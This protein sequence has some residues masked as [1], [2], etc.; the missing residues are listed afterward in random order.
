MISKDFSVTNKRGIKLAATIDIPD[1]VGPAYRSLGAGRFYALFLHCFTCSKELKAIA[2]INSVLAEYGFATVRFDMTGIGSSEGEFKDTNFTTQLEDT[3]SVIEYMKQ[4]YGFPELL[5]GHSLGGPVAV[6]TAAKHNEVK[7]IT[8][9]AAPSEPHKLAQ[10]LKRTRERSIAE[11]M[12]KT[13]IGG[14]TFEFTPQFF[15]DLEKYHMKNVLQNLQKPLL[16]MHSPADTYSDIS[17]AS[18]IF[19]NARHPKSF[20]SLDDMDHL[21]L[22]KEDAEYVGRLIGVWVIHYVNVK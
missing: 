14:V 13:E 22:N 10:K 19:R 3:E 16:I 20:I 18:E 1:I 4:D 21:M 9:I 11:G 7:A 12:A 6:F 2:N 8:T 15:E 17:N 5:I